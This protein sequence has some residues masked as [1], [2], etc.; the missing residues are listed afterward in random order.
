MSIEASRATRKPDFP[1]LE[2]L[3]KDPAMSKEWALA[4]IDREING[5]I[6]V[7]DDAVTHGDYLDGVYALQEKIKMCRRIENNDTAAIR[8][9]AEVEWFERA[10]R[11]MALD[12]LLALAEAED[13]APLRQHLAR[14]ALETC[15]F[16][17][18]G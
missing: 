4:K 17:L 2:D 6:R 3:L 16:A 8:H 11:A 9:M 18:A 10:R 1:E 13:E 14:R 5:E 15:D 7:R 12:K